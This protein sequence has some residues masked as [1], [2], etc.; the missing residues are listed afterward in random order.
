M[1]NKVY[2]NSFPTFINLVNK[3]THY[4]Q[5]CMCAMHKDYMLYQAY[6]PHNQELQQLFIDKHLQG[7][8]S[9]PTFKEVVGYYLNHLHPLK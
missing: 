1:H 7:T 6:I 3:G 4:T 5:I 8:T 9:I 2:R